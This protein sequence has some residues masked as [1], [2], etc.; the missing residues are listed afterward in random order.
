MRQ[1]LEKASDSETSNKESVSPI[2]SGAG[3]CQSE[4]ER[5]IED[6]KKNYRT[7]NC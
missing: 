3:V 6:G 1:W 7:R 5:G 2:F 4:Y